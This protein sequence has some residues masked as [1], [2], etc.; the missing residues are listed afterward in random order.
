MTLNIL[1]PRVLSLRGDDRRMA[2]E[3]LGHETPM[4]TFRH[5]QLAPAHRDDLLEIPAVGAK[6]RSEHGL[7]PLGTFLDLDPLRP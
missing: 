1:S 4:M 3:L 6:G 2:R 5:A 7:S